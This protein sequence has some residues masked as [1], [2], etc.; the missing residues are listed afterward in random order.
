MAAT[1]ETDAGALPNS[2]FRVSLPTPP[3]FN[4]KKPPVRRWVFACDILFRS[5]AVQLDKRV[6]YVATLL[7]G[8]ALTWFESQ[9]RSL[10][11]L[12]YAWTT[13]NTNIVERFRDR[14]QEINDLNKFF[15]ITFVGANLRTY[16]D[17]FTTLSLDVGDAIS[18]RAKLERY[19][20]SLKPRT[21]MDVRRAQP[22]TL[23]GA[24]AE[25]ERAEEINKPI[26]HVRTNRSST[27]HIKKE[28][29]DLRTMDQRPQKLCY[30]CKQPGHFKRDCPE[31]AKNS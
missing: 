23:E 21:R 11:E 19:I 6:A 2:T 24:M 13:F 20:E 17:V 28:D 3:R 30:R 4:G 31:K 15:N 14:N 18:E 16:N 9:V 7:D 25:A 5:G 27:P 1:P 12:A 22:T 29:D 10:G 8:D 26:T